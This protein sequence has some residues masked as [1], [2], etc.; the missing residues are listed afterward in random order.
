[1]KNTSY[2]IDTCEK[3]NLN[4][5]FSI[6]PTNQCKIIGEYPIDDRIRGM[7]IITCTCITR[8]LAIWKIVYTHLKIT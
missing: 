7:S 5:F 8:K 4:A 1:M 3:T 6:G 2:S